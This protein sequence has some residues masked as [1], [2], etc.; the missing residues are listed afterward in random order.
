LSIPTL[1]IMNMYTYE[2]PNIYSPQ[3]GVYAC[4]PCAAHQRD[5]V[6]EALTLALKEGAQFVGVVLAHLE[7]WDT[8]E[9]ETVLLHTHFDTPT[10]HAAAEVVRFAVEWVQ[11]QE[12]GDEY[13]RET[14]LFELQRQQRQR[15]PGLAA[16]QLAAEA[17][18]RGIPILWRESD[19]GLQLQLGYGVCQWVGTVS[20]IAAADEGAIVPPWEHLGPIPIYAVTGECRR[21][22][23]VNRIAEYLDSAGQQIQVCP[24]ADFAATQALLHNPQTTC[25]VVGLDTDDILRRGIA[26]DRCVLSVISDSDGPRPAAATSDDAWLKALGVPMLVCNGP[27]IMDFT[28]PVFAC[29]AAYA[30]HGALP[31]DALEHILPVRT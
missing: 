10:P 25:A 17:Q 11:A 13:D 24:H 28:T 18:S 1:E 23:L 14:R 5:T 15:L 27:A 8:T 2:G 3:A 31:L 30:P 20:E 6:R 26:F 9:G 21:E 4:V 29:L 22:E 7:E 16:I 12:Q 19:A